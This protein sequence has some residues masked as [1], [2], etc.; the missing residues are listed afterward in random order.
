[1]LIKKLT[2]SFL[3]RAARFSAIATVGAGMLA[4]ASLAA[5]ASAQPAATPSAPVAEKTVAVALTQWKVVTGADGKEQLL[6]ASSVKPGDVL[7]YRATY[8]NHTGKT[9]SGLVADLPIPEGLEYLPRSAKPG[10]AL[11]KAATKDGAYAAEPLMRKA[12][13]NRTEPVPYSD[14]RALRWTLGQLP[15]GGET[16][17]TA[18]ARVEVVVPPEP[19]TSALAPQAPPVKAQ[20]AAGA[21]SR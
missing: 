1:M 15:A 8:T 7:E 3:R 11:V 5:P 14:Y 9:V 12:A 17:V 16:A 10:A 19:K 2:Q 13:N 18:R 4:M 20:S 21:A 6:D